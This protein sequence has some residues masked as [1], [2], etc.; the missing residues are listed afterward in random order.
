MASMMADLVP[1]GDEAVSMLAFTTKWPKGRPAKAAA[2]ADK[3][4]N[5]RRAA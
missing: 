3:Q 2:S 4:K 1:C 5:K